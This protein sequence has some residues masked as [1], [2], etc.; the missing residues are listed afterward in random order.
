MINWTPERE[1]K[2]QLL[3]QMLM[4]G[5]SDLPTDKGDMHVTY[6]ISAATLAYWG[7]C[8]SGYQPRIAAAIVE[9]NALKMIDQVRDRYEK[10]VAE[11]KAAQAE[12]AELTAD[13]DAGTSEA[14]AT[15]GDTASDSGETAP[16]APTA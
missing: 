10:H 11:V 15:P 8:K 4:E 13:A 2:A 7:L 3:A 5:K 1:A 6:V 16:P 14:A 12:Q 9:D